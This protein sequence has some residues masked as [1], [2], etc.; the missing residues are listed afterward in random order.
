MLNVRI[1]LIADTHG[2]VHPRLTEVFAGVRHIVH[3]GDIGGGHVLRA[4]EQIA[5]VTFVEGTTTTPPAKTWCGSRSRAFAF[6]SP[7][8]SPVRIARALMWSR[9]SAESRRISWSSGTVTC[10]TMN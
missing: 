3:A 2:A 5:P 4:L 1:G 6:F 7:I 8:S 10:H 9:R